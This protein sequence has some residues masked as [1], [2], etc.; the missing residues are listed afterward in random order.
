MT[1]NMRLGWVALWG[2][3]GGLGCGGSTDKTLTIAWIPKSLGNP[4][5]EAGRDGAALQAMALTQAGPRTVIS[6]YTAPPTEDAAAQAKIVQDLTQQKKADGIAISVLDAAIVGPAI[7]AA[8]AAGIP[9]MTF[10]SDAVASQRFT[11]LGVDNQTGGQA[12]ANMLAKAMATNG[13]SAAA[14]CKVA[15][16]TGGTAPNLEARVTGFTSAMAN[17]PEL[18]IINTIH[19]SEDQA[20]CAMSVEQQMGSAPPDGWFFVGI[21]Q[22]FLPDSAMPLWNAA[23]HA[24]TM[25]TVA[26]DTIP[27]TLVYV[28]DGRISALVGQKYWGWGFDAT[29]MIFD[30]IVNKATFAAFTDSGLDLVCKSNVAAMEA[31]WSSHQFNQTL[32]ACTLAQ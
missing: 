23:A 25:K 15:L 17:H 21:W 26:F 4:V 6:L 30:K 18:T 12:A 28:D 27:Q 19:C 16:L 5:F 31:A 10:D 32:P 29:K 22:L 7:D 14:P 24:G 13:C 8:V 20:L 11:Y 2:M 9:V 3:V 1:T